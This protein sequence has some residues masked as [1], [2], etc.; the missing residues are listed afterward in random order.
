M[1]AVVATPSPVK[2]YGTVTLTLSALTATTTYTVT[3]VSP[4]GHTTNLPVTT[5]GS[6]AATVKYVPSANGNH[7]VN[8]YLYV[9]V[10]QANTTF[11]SS[12]S[13]T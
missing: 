12:G 4:Q 5:D 3:V 1:A 2:G 13:S 9:P 11:N 6:G 8:V 7:T 10:S